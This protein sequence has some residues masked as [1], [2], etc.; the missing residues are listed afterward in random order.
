MLDLDPLEVARQLTIV[1]MAIF[2]KIGPAE[3][4]KQEW[5]RKN[6]KSVA[7]N[8]R[9]MT[10]MSTKITGWIV[11]TI[12]QESDLKRRAYVLKFFIKVGEVIETL[13]THLFTLLYCVY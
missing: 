6:S 3:L 5:S 12:L 11:S 8:V 13:L 10:A 4:M 1:E 2:Q 7:V 9:A